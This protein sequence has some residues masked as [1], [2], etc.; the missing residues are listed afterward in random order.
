MELANLVQIPTGTVCVYFILILLG[1]H[2]STLLFS[3]EQIVGH[4]ISQ[5]RD[6]SH[7]WYHIIQDILLLVTCRRNEH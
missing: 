7:C 3:Y 2:E 5:V 1:K 6:H 4:L